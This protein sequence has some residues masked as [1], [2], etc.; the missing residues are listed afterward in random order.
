M[1]G[2]GPNRVQAS[3][4]SP[5]GSS[6]RTRYQEAPADL[7]TKLAEQGVPWH[8]MDEE[9]RG[10]RLAE[11]LIDEFEQGCTRSRAVFLLSALAKVNPRTRYRTS[12]EV[13]DVCMKEQPV[14]QVEASHGG[15]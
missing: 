8:T 15:K 14:R 4:L 13:L 11:H 6:A 10:W 1:A 5:L 7:R 2:N 9:Q 12:W 3:L